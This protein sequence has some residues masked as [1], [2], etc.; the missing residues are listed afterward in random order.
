[1]AT[2]IAGAFGL[3]RQ[4]V[5][6]HHIP[7]PLPV[8]DTIVYPKDAYKLKRVGDFESV[9]IADSLLADTS[10]TTAV[11]DTL[12]HLTARDTIKVP[13]SLRFIDPF[14][15]KYYVALLDSL[16]HV[17]VRDSLQRSSDSLKV[18]ADTLL[19]KGLDSLSSGARAL[20]ISDSLDWRKLD[21][22]YVSDSTARAK[23]AFLAWY[24]SLSRRE[25]KKY[26]MEQALPAKLA[27]MD[28]LRKLEEDKKAYKDS[29]IEYTPR[30]LSTFAVPDSMQYKRIIEWTVDQDFHR[31]DVKEPDTTYNYHF[32]DY[33]FLRKDVNASWLGV[34]GSPL[35]YYNFHLRSSEEDVEFYNALEAWS[36]SP[37]TIPHY[38]TKTPHTELAYFGTLLAGDAKE[39]DNLHILT[40]QNILPEL[41]FTISFD[42]FGGGGMLEAEQTINK[43]FSP[44]LNYIGKKY[45]AHLG[46]I[47]NMVDRQENGGIVDNMWIRDTTVEAREIRVAISGSASKV[48]KNT[49]FLNQQYRIPF[50]FIEKLKA[51]KD[52]SAVQDTTLAPDADTLRRDITTA[53]IGH[54]T[55]W[56]S[57][58]RK[59]TDN[60]TSQYGR[61]FYHDVFKYGQQSADSLRTIKLD[62]KV[63]L[64]LQ[65]WGSESIV[66]KLDVGV[67]DRLMQWF[68][69]TSVRPKLHSENSVYVYAGAEGQWRKYLNWDAKAHFNV[70]GPAI[71]DTKIEANA[72][73]NFYPFRRARK[74]P[75]SVGAHFETNL[76]TPDYYTRMLQTNH[77][78]WENDFSKIST[79]QI[80]GYIS[81]PRWRMSADVGYSLLVNNIYYDTLGIVR[82]NTIPMSV[83]SA[84]LRKEF[85]L[86]PMHLDNRVLV[87]YSS[88]PDIVPV[89]TVALNLRW[90]AQFVVQRNEAKTHNVMEMQIGINAFYNSQWYAPSW[91][92][93]IGVFHNQH[94]NLY[95]NGPYFDI[96]MNIQWK[97]CCIFLKYQNFGR[98]WPMRR[99]DYFT[100]DHYITTLD[101]T[102]GLKLGIFWPFYFSTEKHVSHGGNH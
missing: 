61:A 50:D 91:N 42:R 85:V 37:R 83:L 67:G 26:D 55:E 58:T 54:S 23:A 32:Y 59:Y 45:M 25:R 68:D 6:Y 53:F 9:K 60:I 49:F 82:Q 99:K 46:Y 73:L 40:T 21:S 57:Y 5:E 10:D 1:M 24:N 90:Y 28:S 87:Q 12:P 44:R 100:A 69:S 27:E 11:L 74:S 39:S 47:Y 30:I 35:Q 19:A 92:P 43:T 70:L 8:Q 89:P 71:G 41:N 93:A 78:S 101:G 13:D 20:A 2:A 79:S 29:V 48:T 31:I 94:T 15:F 7:D 72:G 17:I 18:V 16:T 62:N 97:R 56:S 4:G 38:N 96:F 80:R 84:S 63:F 51:H 98:G 86:G 34:A 81:I 66:S 65:P 76:K 14:R 52:T 22:I 88:E 33:P 64:R 77:F 3:G 36:Y 102:D 95:E 75:I